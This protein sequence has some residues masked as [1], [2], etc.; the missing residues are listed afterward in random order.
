ML[1]IECYTFSVYDC[2]ST[3]II[4][5]LFLSI[6]ML[7]S[8]HTC[9]VLVICEPTVYHAMH[10]KLGVGAWVNMWFVWSFIHLLFLDNIRF[11][12]NITLIV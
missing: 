10:R 7:L 6:I 1:C 11:L 5:R 12:H 2:T 4:T 3:F 9:S 8:S